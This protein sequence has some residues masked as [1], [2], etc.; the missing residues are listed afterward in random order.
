MKIKEVTA[1]LE[2]RFPLDLQEDFD[3]CGVQCGDI[4]QEITGALVCFEISQDIIDEAVALHANLVVSH[5]PILLKRGICKIEPTDRVG[6]LI[7]KALAHHIVL[8]AMH[9]NVDSARGGGNDVFAEKLGLR[10]VQVLVP[11]YVNGLM[12]EGAGL[13]RIGEI[14]NGMPLLDYLQEVKQKLNLETLR[15]YGD[16]QHQV[17][18][19][20]VC[21]G[22]GASFIENALS[23][24]ADI[25]ITG[26]IKY[27]DFFRAN[28][29]MTIVDIGHYEGEW[30]IREILYKEIKENF[31]TFATAISKMDDLEIYYL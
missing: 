15:Y 27:H 8:Y 25:Y 16:P 17:R 21:G 20:A 24:G 11:H 19:V 2:K 4:D 6:G 29:R 5:H 1:H 26:D 7:C 12:V 14:P 23:A 10:D 3:N 18:K 22:G 31:T 13:G 30:F 9:T 28:R